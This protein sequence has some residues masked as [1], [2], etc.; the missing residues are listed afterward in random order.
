[1]FGGKVNLRNQLTKFSLVFGSLFFHKNL[2]K[3]Y[4]VFTTFFPPG[5]DHQTLKTKEKFDFVLVFGI[6]N[7]AVK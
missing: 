5:M 4:D 1:M 2:A 3:F 6:F 7:Y